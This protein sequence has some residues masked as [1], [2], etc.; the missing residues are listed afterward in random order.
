M[1]E[2]IIKDLKLNFPM[3]LD[4]DNVGWGDTSD[5]GDRSGNVTIGA[6]DHL[7][8]HTTA[9][10]GQGDFISISALDLVPFQSKPNMLQ[11]HFHA[12]KF[13]P[14]YLLLIASVVNF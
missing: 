8:A 3:A 2:N 13:S 1:V 4:R 11:N 9:A 12:L 10:R 7:L 6:N 14:L 5:S